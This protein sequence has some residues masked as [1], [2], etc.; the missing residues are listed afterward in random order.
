MWC[1]TKVVYSGFTHILETWTILEFDHFKSRHQR[2]GKILEYE[3]IFGA[4][5]YHVY[6]CDASVQI[7]VSFSSDAAINLS[8]LSSGKR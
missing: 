4:F 3:P 7:L 2:S 6:I 1:P 8:V 5:F